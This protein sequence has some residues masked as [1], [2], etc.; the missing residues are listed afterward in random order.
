M[1]VDWLSVGTNKDICPPSY[2]ADGKY[3]LEEESEACV[4]HTLECLTGTGDFRI[5]FFDTATSKGGGQIK[6]DNFAPTLDIQEMRKLMEKAPFV[7]WRGYNLHFFP[8]VSKNAKKYT[9]KDR[10]TATPS[11]FCYRS[12]GG[13]ANEAWPF[14]NHK[15]SDPFGGFQEKEGTFNSL[16]FGVRRTGK[17]DFLL[18]VSANGLSYNQSHTWKSS[19]E[20]WIPVVCRLDNSIKV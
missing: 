4:S 1:T 10:G 12:S 15:F 6:A 2:Y 5:A 19:E 9:P 3:C 14:S 8:H 16:T 13:S 11:S 20:S 17:S 7:N 18:S